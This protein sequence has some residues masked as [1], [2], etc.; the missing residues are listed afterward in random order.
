VW[1]VAASG[2]HVSRDFWRRAIKSYLYFV[3]QIRH[4]PQEITHMP[5]RGP[6]T[7]ELE[8]SR[9]L[10]VQGLKLTSWSADEKRA[11][12]SEAFDKLDMGKSYVLEGCDEL[13]TELGL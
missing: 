5:W 11:A 12:L 13:R 6:I 7:G 10:F 1:D 8:A 4:A 2:D 9:D 3:L